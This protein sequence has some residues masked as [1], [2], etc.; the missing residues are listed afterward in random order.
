MKK[1]IF[2]ISNIVILA[3]LLGNAQCQ[4]NFVPQLGLNLSRITFGSIA[5]NVPGLG[6]IGLAPKTLAGI[7]IGANLEIPLKSDFYLKPGIFF[8][9]KGSKYGNVTII[10]LKSDFLEIPIDALYKLK[11]NPVKLLFFAGPYF[12]YKV[13][14]NDKE[15]FNDL[16]G[17]NWPTTNQTLKS[18]DLGINFGAGVE[19]HKFQLCFHY[20][21]GL[22]DL[23]PSGQKM[24]TRNF[25]ISIGYVIGEN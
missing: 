15:F 16:Y 2:M 8:S 4:I 20:E 11:I 10:S 12:A 1:K 24:N 21:L 22:L 25:S 7:N 3:F 13:G 23:A 6:G 9:M 14:G 19:F 17:P 5:G 18:F